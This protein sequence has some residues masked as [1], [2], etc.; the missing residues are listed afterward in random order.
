MSW[1]GDSLVSSDTPT[2]RFSFK[3]LGEL[4]RGKESSNTFFSPF[5]LML[6]LLML[7]EGASGET[8]DAMAGVLE[9]AGVDPET[10]QGAVR[11]LKSALTMNEPGLEL[12][13]ANSLWCDD[14]LQAQSAFL[15]LVAENYAAEV[16]RLSLQS[17]QAGARING[18]VAEKTRGKISKIV[19]E[20]DLGP[21][22]LL[23]AVN[24]IYFK[25][26]WDS[27]FEERLTR[28]EPFLVS[29][30]EPVRIPR[31]LRSGEFRYCETRE[32][33]AVRLPYRG[34]RVGMYVFLPAK[35]S[36]LADFLG[37]IA[38]AQW[39]RWLSDFKEREGTVGLPRF[40]L[41]YGVYL[42][43]ILSRIGM[44]V[45]FDSVRARFERLAP[46]SPPLWVDEIIHRALV[47]VNEEGTVAAAV[48]ATV[49]VGVALHPV[50]PPP[51]FEMIVD[52]PFFFVICDDLSGT[53]LF[54]GAVNDPRGG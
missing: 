11:R 51:P 35:K 22:A 13:V 16:V 40:K 28:V 5:S 18:W 8:R 12:A 29:G 41:E 3:L 9:F 49:T 6:C 33:Q 25:G 4:T 14:R 38:A 24:A 23:V 20:G 17:P 27:P 19:S 26:S 37:T 44:G 32:F 39:D 10:W 36:S 52:R 21:L 43:S 50:S 42:K 2:K 47:E 31:M 34:G 53:V 54:I 7:W 46:P 48:T 15:A 30:R 1:A 45:V